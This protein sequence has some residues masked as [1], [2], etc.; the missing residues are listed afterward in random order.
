[1]IEHLW[2]VSPDDLEVG[3]HIV[4]SEDTIEVT[5]LEAIDDGVRV[6]GRIIRGWGKGKT[7]RSWTFYSDQKIDIERG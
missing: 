2:D 6:F 1:M 7:I 5:A 3:D 4:K